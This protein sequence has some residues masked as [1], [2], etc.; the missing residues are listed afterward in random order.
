MAERLRDLADRQELL[1][2]AACSPKLVAEDAAYRDILAREFNCVV[3]ENCMKAAYLQPERGRFDFA[4]TDQLL[5][6]ARQN[7][8][9]VR[10]H[11]LVWHNQVPEWLRQ[12]SFSKS[13]ALDVLRGHITG[14]LNHCRGAV[15]CWDV[16]NEG[17]NDDGGWRENSPWF[18]MIGREYIAHA[19]RYAHEADPDAR[20]FYNDY[21]MEQPGRKADACF[22]MLQRLLGRGVPIH[23]VGFQF[24]LGVENRLDLPACVANMRRFAEL[25]LAIHFT[26]MDMGIRKPVTDELRQQQADEYANR[27]QIA[28]ETGGVS[29]LMFWGF[30]DRHSWIPAFTKGE[31]DEALLFDRDYQPKPAYHAVRDA[32]RQALTED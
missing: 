4:H 27:V 29:A 31:C 23:G 22:R 19:F 3:A 2:G 15:F 11:T 13:E 17:L 12:G 21:G 26:E 32:L 28:I 18:K 8:M 24:H 9:A 20:L 1:I 25:G 10:G 5:E 16:V 30:T 14:V 6:F 7:R